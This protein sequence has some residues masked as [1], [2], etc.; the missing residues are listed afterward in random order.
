MV[1]PQIFLDHM[2]DMLG[3]E[4]ASFLASYDLPRRYGLRINPLKVTAEE[5]EELAPFH[6]KKIPWIPGGYEYGEADACSKHPFY[7]AGLY[8]L[9]EPTAMTPAVVLDV[10]PGEK[11]LD[12]CAAPGGKA[13]ALGGAMQGEGLLFAN[14]ISASRCR[15]LQKNIELFG[16]TNAFVA[17]A[18][19]AAITEQFPLF[20]DKILLDAPC[21]GEGMFRKD[22]GA[23]RAWTPQR[24]EAC[25]KI[26]KG[27]I[28]HAADMLR[29][30]GRMLYSTCTFSEKENEE[31][32]LY[33]L[34]NRPEMRLIDIPQRDGYAQ[35]LLG[36]TECV[37]LWPHK[38]GGEGHFLALLEKKADPAQAGSVYSLQSAG[39]DR[40]EAAGDT[41]ERKREKGR[42]RTN[43][44]P[45]FGKPKDGRA[46]GG[47]EQ[48]LELAASFLTSQGLP[49][50]KNR[51]VLGGES[52]Y[53][54][55]GL[56]PQT[57]PLPFF[58][59]G[60]YL[61][62][63]KKD[64]FEPSGACAM[65]MPG[66]EHPHMVSFPMDDPRLPRYLRGETVELERKEETENGWQLVCVEGFPLGWGKSAGKLL[67]NKYHPGWRH[68]SK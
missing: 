41:S 56:L 32:I 52:V 24:S 68:T 11:V 7:D 50:E 58:R 15:A 14:D 10:H 44:Q 63:L 19:P 66:R 31:V 54:E 22:E 35:G 34:D 4:Y 38:M 43:H 33:L 59:N 67:K 20:F 55:T 61:G 9:Q 16:I 53:Y 12:L 29:P 13:T 51:M 65:A 2:K 18:L 45:R 30:G 57:I 6:L 26:Q 60:L 21:S 36:L 42:K 17:N 47:R 39:A 64:R 37:R 62:D 46:A 27:L 1:L 25:A 5:F 48:G 8:Y 3:E 23:I 28:L 49:L 40:M